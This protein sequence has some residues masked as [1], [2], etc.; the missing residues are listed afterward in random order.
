MDDSTAGIILGVSLVV[1]GAVLLYVGLVR[2]RIVE[3]AQH[4]VQLELDK[5]IGTWPTNIHDE[6]VGQAQ[7]AVGEALNRALP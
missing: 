4:Q 5:L 1:A 7:R 6:I 2:G 3:E